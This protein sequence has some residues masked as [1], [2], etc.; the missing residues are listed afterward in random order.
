M[1]YMVMI[2]SR[3]AAETAL[4]FLRVCSSSFDVRPVPL[5]VLLTRA[6]SQ[7]GSWLIACGIIRMAWHQS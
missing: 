7:P 6:T 5:D 2:D 4:T 3:G 1:L